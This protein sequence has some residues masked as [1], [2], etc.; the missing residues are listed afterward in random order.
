MKRYSPEIE[1][2][3]IEY[4][5]HDMINMKED[6]KGHYLRVSEIRTLLRGIVD[7][8]LTTQTSGPLISTAEN[9]EKI[10]KELD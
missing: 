5:L 2:F 8:I 10:L 4:N 9:L 7:D 3:F 6:T 1:R